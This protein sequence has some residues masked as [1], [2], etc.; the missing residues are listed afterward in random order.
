MIAE[1]NERDENPPGHIGWITNDTGGKYVEESTTSVG[2]KQQTVILKDKFSC[3][4]MVKS[5]S[6]LAMS[7]RQVVL[8]FDCKSK[9]QTL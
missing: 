2:P 5:W 3:W 9:H 7:L 1:T 4:S 6:S 8:C